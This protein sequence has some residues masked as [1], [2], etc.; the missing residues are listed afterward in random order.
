VAF[1]VHARIRV[2]QRVVHLRDAARYDRRRAGCRATLEAVRLERDV[3]RGTTRPLAR[4]VQRDR[5][6]VTAGRRLGNP[7]ADNLPLRHD[8]S[9]DRGVR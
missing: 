9:A 7:L 8:N 2:T 4:L 3:E 5:L 6:G 1:A